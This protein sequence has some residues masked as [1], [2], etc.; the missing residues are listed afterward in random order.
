IHSFR[1]GEADDRLHNGKRVARP[2]VDFARQQ[3]LAFL[4]LLAVGDVDDD[5]AY[6]GNAPV[7]P[8]VGRGR[9][10]APTH[11]AARTLDAELGLKRLRVPEQI[12]PP[13]DQRKPIFRMNERPDHV[14]PNGE[15]LRV[16]PEDA[17]L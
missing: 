11:F 1:A 6:P 9:A 8:G 14:E 12:L 15:A 7:R 13:A 3:R 16:D 5:T 10:D 17:A 2:V 4:R